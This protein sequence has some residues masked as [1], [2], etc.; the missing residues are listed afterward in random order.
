MTTTLPERAP[1]QSPVKSAPTIT[2]DVLATP[3]RTVAPPVDKRVKALQRFAISITA[4]TILGHLFLGFEQAPIT[5]VVCVLMGYFVDLVLET[6]NA[7]ATGRAPGYAGG[8][9]SLVIYL[10]PTHIAGLACAM[11]LYGNASLWPYLLAITVAICGKHFVKIK[12]NGRYRHFLNP[13]NSGIVVVL[14]VF[15]WVSIAPPYHFTNNTTGGL[16]WILPLGVLMAGTMLNAGLTGRM[17]LIFG[18]VG[19]FAAQAVVRWLVLDHV[20]LAAL[21]PI[22]GLAFILFTNYMITDP[23]TTPFKRRNQVVFGLTAAAVY[24]VLVVS[25]VVFGLFFALA[26]TCVL[27]AAVLLATPYLRPRLGQAVDRV[28]ARRRAGAGT[29]EQPVLATVAGGEK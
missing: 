28:T 21:A 5:P 19:G 24:G 18:W 8:W 6:L 2:T 16:D 26:I 29:G 4:F 1:G 7:R 17:P 22:T 14:L 27:R 23:G 25:H 9:R 13:S 12:I 10:L 20:L 11:L 3:P 15:P